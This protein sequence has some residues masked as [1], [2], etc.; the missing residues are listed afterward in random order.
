MPDKKKLTEMLMLMYRIRYFEENLKDLYNY[1]SYLK[2]TDIAADIYDF[3]STGAVLGACH[4]Y[5]G[6]EAVAVGVCAHLEPTDYITSTHRGHGHAIAKGLDLKKILAELMGRED[7]YCHG[8]GGSMH[9]FCKEL[10]LLGGNGIIGAGLPIATGA[11]F[12][13]KYRGTR[14]VAV[15]FFG[16]GAV[17]QGTFN[18]SLNMASLWKLPVIYVCENNLW[19]ATTPGEIAHAIPHLAEKAAGYGMPGKIVDGQDV[20]AV[21]EAAGEAIERARRGDGPTLLECKT[22]R[23]EAHCG[24]T[25]QNKRQHE[26]PEQLKEWLKRDPITLFEQRLI[27]DGIMTAQEQ[28]AMKEAAQ[29]EVKEAEAFARRSP[30]PTLQSIE[31]RL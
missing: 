22:F 13:A 7:G 10:G 14:Q 21:Y 11:A 28:N 3:E 26:N 23:F 5:I 16:D 24:V 29:R 8:C 19:A 31:A 6:Q 18:E 30:Y 1:Q 12:S 15:C 9:I 4:L 25:R 27:R 2:K 20:M 17:N